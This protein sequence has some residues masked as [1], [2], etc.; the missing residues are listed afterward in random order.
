MKTKVWISIG[1]GIFVVLFL[2]ILL[3]KVFTPGNPSARELT[4]QEAKEIAQQ[5]YSG[6]VQEIKQEADHYVIQLERI[7]GLYEL[8]INAETGEVSS[9]KR[10]KEKEAEKNV[11]PTPSQQ[12]GTEEEAPV[13]EVQSRLTE[14]KAAE[15]ALKEVPGEVD[16][17][18][19]ENING[20]TYFLV[21]VEVNDGREATVEI[22]GIT[23]EVQSL[24]WDEDDDDE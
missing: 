2:F 12:Q 5:R 20:I 16:D 10:L 8:Q 23:G 15:I 24:T 1:A 4:A 18:D 21:D 22:N 11:E 14:E 13:E 17:I 19:V 3:T 9:L 7:T 6:L